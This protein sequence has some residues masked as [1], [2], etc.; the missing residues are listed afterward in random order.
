MVAYLIGIT[1][2]DPLKYDL[3]FERFLNPERTELP[4]IDTD[5]CVDR[6]GEVIQYCRE[7]YGEDR[8][9][10]IATYGRMKAKNA[11]RDVGRVMDVPLADVGKLCKAVPDEMKITIKDALKNPDFE[12]LYES[13]E[14]NK[15]LVDDAMRCE[16]MARNT[17]MHAA[18]VIISSRPLGRY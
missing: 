8:V 5:F 6:R 12:K 2:L 18:G 4:D 11:I 16:G 10:Q 17:G 7:R 1:Q 3:L 13:S 14:V 15:R 9:S